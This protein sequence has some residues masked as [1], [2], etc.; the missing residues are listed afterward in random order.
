MR[1]VLFSVLTVCLVIF[2]AGCAMTPVAPPRGVL[3][4]DQKAPLFPAA[5]TGSVR[6]T[7]TAYNVLL[8]VGWG[9]CSVHTAA[10]NAGITKIKNVDYRSSN[11]CFVYQEFD[12]IVYGEK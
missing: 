10:R 1:G 4:N 3:Y 12:V 5:A 11:Y 6:G 2:A 9:D 7:S 8:L